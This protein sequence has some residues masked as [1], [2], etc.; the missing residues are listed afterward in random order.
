MVGF[1]LTL[2]YAHLATQSEKERACDYGV[3]RS[4]VKQSQ[5]A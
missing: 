1:I 5:T 3:T 4:C 2:L